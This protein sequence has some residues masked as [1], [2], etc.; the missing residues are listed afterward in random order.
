MKLGEDACMAGTETSFL[1]PASERRPRRLAAVLKTGC[2]G[3]ASKPLRS[4]AEL[5]SGMHSSCVNSYPLCIT[6]YCLMTS[7]A[8]QE[9]L[10]WPPQSRHH[11]DCAVEFTLAP[12]INLSPARDPVCP[13]VG[14]EGRV[15]FAG[16]GCKKGCKRV[17]D[18]KPGG[19]RGGGG[20]GCSGPRE[21][22]CRCLSMHKMSQRSAL[23]DCTGGDRFRSVDAAQM[24]LPSAGKQFGSPVPMKQSTE[25]EFQA[26]YGWNGV[27]H[28][29]N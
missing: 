9:L 15:C 16:T 7:N 23:L 2:L 28:V 5:V 26:T 13:R 4:D 14:G 1:P 29:L 8:M 20:G 11:R 27:S 24:C 17:K 6:I 21:L 3:V 10:V 12:R 18:N 25:Q 22:C 19:G